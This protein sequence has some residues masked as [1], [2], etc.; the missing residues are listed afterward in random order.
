MS[1]DLVERLDQ[2]ATLLQKH[3]QYFIGTLLDEAAAEI[4]SLR[5]QVAKERAG[6]VAMVQGEAEAYR[7]NRLT[8]SCA[9]LLHLANAI[10]AHQDKEPT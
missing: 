4:R 3:G 9:L 1:D 8:A 6:I 10:E 5:E 2:Q 7:K